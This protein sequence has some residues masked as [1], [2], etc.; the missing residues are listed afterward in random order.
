MKTFRR[1]WCA[2]T[3]RD[4]IEIIPEA[5][6]ECFALV[7][8]AYWLIAPL[9]LWWWG[10]SGGIEITFLEWVNVQV[11]ALAIALAGLLLAA[12]RADV[13]AGWARDRW[14]D[15]LPLMLLG[16]FLVLALIAT[17]IHP[18]DATWTGDQYR[19]E[20]MLSFAS[21]VGFFFLASQVFDRS[22]RRL[23]L[24][25][26]LGLVV[27]TCVVT[28][29]A[30]L[31]DGWA[32][33]DW[34]LPHRVTAYLHQFNHYG[35]LLAVGGALAASG[36]LVA[37]RGRVRAALLAV[38]AIILLTLLLNDT[39]GAYVALASGCVGAV[40]WLAVLRRLTVTRVVALVAV[41]VIVHLGAET[42]GVGTFGEL[43]SLGADVQAVSAG[44]ADAE[45]AG[46]GRWGLWVITIEQIAASPWFGHG[47]EGIADLLPVGFGRPH[48]EYLQYAV[49][50]GAPALVA[51]VAAIAAVF[52]RLVKRG[53][54][55]DAIT[56]CAAVGA[57]TYLVSA[58]FGNT[59]YYTA[60]LLFLLL[61]VVWAGVRVR[62]AAS[63]ATT[64]ELRPEVDE[65][66][67]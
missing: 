27:V 39:L 28:F 52:V 31:I 29:A 47:I 36:A 23:L 22:R 26:L 10:E 49:F 50:F 14:R 40:V 43:G 44:A 42:L 54:G 66:T 51:Y 46:T 16:A 17:L 20:S 7:A 67:R 6:Y 1:V 45:S 41:A 63:G 12:R 18:T 57:A 30:V 11:G 55:V 35:Y 19:R 3:V 13:G 58:C 34:A 59:M 53:S 62:G 15:N 33:G 38:F 25:L 4:A 9:L 48:N 65:Y 64:L 5:F 37:A 32:G 60:P 21:Y 24:G 56:V 2:R 61:G 8:L